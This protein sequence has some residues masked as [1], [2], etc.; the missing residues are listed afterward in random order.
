MS[1]PSGSRFDAAGSLSTFHAARRL[2]W[3]HAMFAVP[4]SMAGPCSA[5]VKPT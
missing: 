3:G 2:D 5:S 1:G 4:V